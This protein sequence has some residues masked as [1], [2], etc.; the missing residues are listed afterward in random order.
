FRIRSSWCSFMF[1]TNTA[2]AGMPRTSP[3]LYRPEH[4]RLLSALRQ[5]LA[6]EVHARRVISERRAVA[7]ARRIVSNAD[8]GAERASSPPIIFPACA[9]GH[10]PNV[11]LY[12]NSSQTSHHRQP[13]RPATAA[14]GADRRLVIRGR[15]GRTPALLP[16]PGS[17]RPTGSR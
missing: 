11:S 13:N 10:L 17:T 15:C 5:W 7:D 1:S 12:A 6:A 4:G 9:N 14:Y 16:N 8:T 3:F 2:I